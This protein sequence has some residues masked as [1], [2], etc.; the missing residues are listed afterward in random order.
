MW[1]VVQVMNGT[2]AAA[3]EKCR[4]AI[5]RNLATHIFTPTCEKMKKYAGEWQ[6]VTEVLFRGYVFIESDASADSLLDELAH[7]PSVVMPVQIG[8]GFYPI[9]EDEE[10][11][12]RSLMDEK[13]CICLSTGHI[14]EGNLL[15]DQ[16]PLDGKTAWVKKIDRHK[17]VAELEILLWQVVRRIRVGLEVTSKN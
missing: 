15:I 2:E 5:S 16:G 1:Y 14:V 6:I 9:R 7:I 4:H 8:G 3:I 10:L 13:G 11:F 17:R 12:L